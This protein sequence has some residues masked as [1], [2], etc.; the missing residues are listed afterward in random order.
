MNLLQGRIQWWN[1]T[2]LISNLQWLRTSY[3]VPSVSKQGT[4]ITF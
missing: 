1:S 2:P 3:I 4:S